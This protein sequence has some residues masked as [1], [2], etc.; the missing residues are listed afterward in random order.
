MRRSRYHN[1]LLQVG[2]VC[3]ALYSASSL[4]ARPKEDELPSPSRTA[5][6]SAATPAATAQQAP[7]T[8]D[9][10]AAKLRAQ[11]QTLDTNKDGYLSQEEIAAGIAARRTQL[12]AAIRKQ[13]DAA[14]VAMDT[15][16]DGQLSRDEFLAGG[17]K[18]SPAV[19][20]GSKAL[21]RFDVNKDG[22][23]S[24]SEYLT[25]AVGAF[26]K[27]NGTKAPVANTKKPADH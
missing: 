6:T 5:A 20:D 14:F 17:P 22:K 24:L 1:H 4:A 25:V 23:V 26:D 2:V 3:A 11:F 10:V 18:F 8:R 9:A 12:I 15:N 27:A 16:K 21:S 13:R 7:L 19:P